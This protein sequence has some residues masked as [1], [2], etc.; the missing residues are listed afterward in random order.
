MTSIAVVL[1]VAL[2]FAVPEST[3]CGLGFQSSEDRCEQATAR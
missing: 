1:A 2:Q 3:R